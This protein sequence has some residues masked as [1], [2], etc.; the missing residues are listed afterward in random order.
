MNGAKKTIEYKVHV[1]SSFENIKSPLIK[2]GIYKDVDFT[3]RFA[4]GA[5]NAEELSFM[6]F[7]ERGESHKNPDPSG[8]NGSFYIAEDGIKLTVI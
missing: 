2:N 1:G 8:V 6:I 7:P 4:R 3:T 5:E